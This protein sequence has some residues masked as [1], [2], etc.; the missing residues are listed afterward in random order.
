MW[1]EI[2]SASAQSRVRTAEEV[3]ARLRAGA[4][5]EE[6]EAARARVAVAAAQVATLEKG[7][8]DATCNPRS[9]ASSPKNWSR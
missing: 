6:I 9:A 1:R 5:P 4:R 2:G 8:T 3:L 7:L